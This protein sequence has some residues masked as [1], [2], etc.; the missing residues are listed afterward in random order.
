MTTVYSPSVVTTVV[1]DCV[2]LR[3]VDVAHP[4]LAVS[5][6]T[7]DHASNVSTFRNIVRAALSKCSDETCSFIP[8]LNI[9][10]PIQI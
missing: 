4:N 5:I 10:Y 2:V 9:G 1:K 7:A 6:S 3:A 8:N